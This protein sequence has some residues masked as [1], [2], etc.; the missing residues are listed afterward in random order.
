MYTILL[1]RLVLNPDVNE[2]VE[3]LYAE[4]PHILKEDKI[5]KAKVAELV[6]RIQVKLQMEMEQEEEG[7]GE[8]G[9]GEEG[10]GEGEDHQEE[11]DEEF[12]EEDRPHLNNSR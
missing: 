12:E 5:P 3:Q 1:K 10:E 2:V 7:E 11:Y 9:E 4:H 8:E 6:E